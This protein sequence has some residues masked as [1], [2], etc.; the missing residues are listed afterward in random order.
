MRSA[1]R[2]ALGAD[3]ILAEGSPVAPLLQSTARNIPDRIHKCCRSGWQRFC[4]EY[5]ILKLRML[6]YL[7]TGDPDKM[8]TVRSRALKCAPE[9]G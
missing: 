8:T 6:Y 9:M 7:R 2:F 3:V 1:W 4:R 5:V